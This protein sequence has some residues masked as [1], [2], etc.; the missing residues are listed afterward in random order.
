MNIRVFSAAIVAFSFIWVFAEEPKKDVRNV[1]SATEFQSA[2]LTKLSEEELIK[3]SGFL[4]GWKKESRSSNEK[5]KV[6]YLQ[7]KSFGNERKEVEK[8]EEGVS[9]IRSTITGDF[10]GWSGKT[11]FRLDNGQVWRQTD[12]KTFYHRVKD[13]VVIIRRGVFNSFYLKVDGFGSKCKVERV[14]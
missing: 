4:Y 8:K 12:N 6:S 10:K 5:T 13:P 9:E 1:L 11:V 7:E 2:G 14:K 3:L